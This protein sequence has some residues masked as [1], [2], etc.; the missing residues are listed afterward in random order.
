MQANRKLTP[1]PP[2][3]ANFLAGVI[4]TGRGR[5]DSRLEIASA[6]GLDQSLGESGGFIVADQFAKDLWS[7]VYST[8]Q[9]LS[10]CDRQPM[11]KSGRLSIPAVKEVLR[12]NG[13]RFGGIQMAWAG[14]A[15]AAPVDKLE[16]ALTDLELRK[17]I[18]ALYGSDELFEDATVLA[19]VLKRAFAMEAVFRIEDAI[20]NGD[21][22][23]K[24]LGVL[25]SPAL[26]TV[27]PEGGQSAATVN[28]TNLIKMAARLWGPS[29]AN[30]VWLMSNEV[31]ERIAQEA[32]NDT[33]EGFSVGEN[34]AVRTL[35]QMPVELSEHTPRLGDAGDILLGDFS[36]YILA[37]KDAESLSS[38]H[39]KFQEDE[40]ALKVRYRVDGAPGWAAPIT[41]KNSTATQ[42]PFVA[43]G[44]RE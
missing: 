19:A 36:Q 27:A 3:F 10:R 24:P 6:M 21:G 44:S 12:S 32:A 43:L 26:I 38:I 9:I 13:S 37:E 4:R 7:R 33:F 2:P 14:E 31:W 40:S 1:D 42:S 22:V 15:D 28:A 20:V 23:A 35:L 30:A 5:V 39:V 16:L 29:H 41:P 17:L 34:G 8:G 11:P 18:G 25:N